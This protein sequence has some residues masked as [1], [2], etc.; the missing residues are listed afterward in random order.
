MFEAPS[1]CLIRHWVRIHS[2]QPYDVEICVVAP[3]ADYISK[4]IPEL[5]R[6][7]DLRP[8]V[9]GGQAAWFQWFR[10]KPS[11]PQP[12]SDFWSY[13]PVAGGEYLVGALPYYLDG[14]SERRYLYPPL[15]DYIGMFVLSDCVRY[16]QDLWRSVVQGRETGVPGL[17]A[18]FIDVSRRRFPN[19]VLDQLFKEAFEYWP[20]RQVEPT[21]LE[22]THWP[23]P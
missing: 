22:T 7:F 20:K 10:S 19:L 21:T 9:H 1:R 6:D 2:K 12:P 23:M 5:A 17:I 14:R 4:R 15:S 11:L 18:L 3:N 8:N 16:K 13:N